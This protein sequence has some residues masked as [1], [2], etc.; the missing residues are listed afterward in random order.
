M[1]GGRV[2]L[3]AEGYNFCSD[4]KKREKE[5]SPEMCTL[6]VARHFYFITLLFKVYFSLVIFKS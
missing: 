1:I 2:E 4:Q 6:S 5:N 3:G